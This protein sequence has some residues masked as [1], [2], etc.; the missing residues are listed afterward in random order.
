VISNIKIIYY[1]TSFI[2]IYIFIISFKSVAGTV[3]LSR[4][5]FNAN[6]EFEYIQNFKILQAAFQKNNIDKVKI[7]SLII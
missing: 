2:Y 4:V 1:L 5:K 6:Q 3:H 7:L